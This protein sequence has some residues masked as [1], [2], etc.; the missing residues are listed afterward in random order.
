MIDESSRMEVD[1]ERVL[2]NRERGGEE[3]EEDPGKALEEA[4]LWLLRPYENADEGKVKSL[5]LDT[6]ASE[7][8]K[9]FLSEI[10]QVRQI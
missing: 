3:E 8:E 10:Q 6:E 7:V 1:C 4:F 2:E 5:Q 9:A